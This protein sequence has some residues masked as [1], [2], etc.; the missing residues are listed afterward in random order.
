MLTGLQ[1]VKKFPTFQ[2]IQTCITTLTAAHHLSLLQAIQ[3]YSTIIPSYFSIIPFHSILPSMCRSSKQSTSLGFP[4]K[5]PH[6]FLFFPICATCT[7]YLILLILSPKQ[8]L[9]R[10]TNHAAAYYAVFNNLCQFVLVIPR[11]FP[12]H[13]ILEQLW[14]MFLPQ[15]DRPSFTSI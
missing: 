13:L 3:T 5:A 6:A 9:V 4:T 15:C 12:R 7:I 11:Y 8:Y 2:R 14:P 10:S 1:V